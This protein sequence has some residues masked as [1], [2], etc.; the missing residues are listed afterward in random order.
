MAL[1]LGEVEVR[2][3]ALVEQA[4]AVVEEVEPEVE[5]AAGELVAVHEHVA[6]GQVPAARPD[7][8]D[9]RV[10]A[11]PVGLLAGIELDRAL[12]RVGQVGLAVEVVAPRRRVRV[13]EVGHEAAGAGVERVDDHLAV[14]RPGDLDAP[15]LQVGGHGRD[16]PVALAHLA[17]L[18][19]EVGQLAG[20]EAR[21]ALGARGEEL[22]ASR[23]EAA[24]EL[25]DERE[26]VRAQDLLVAPVQGRAKLQAGDLRAPRA[27]ASRGRGRGR[28]D[29]GRCTRPA[30]PSSG[31][32]SSLPCAERHEGRG[33]I[34]W[35]RS[36]QLPFPCQPS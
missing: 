26:R 13:L 8:E 12:D 14:D 6:L 24:V 3:A 28:R 9:G 34:Q 32:E 31:R 35:C 10:V 29:P 2:A 18:R 21:L 16:A 25:G 19:Q 23:V 11:E 1:E 7:E 30:R 36:R 20:V 22:A 15:V 33:Q 5:E 17:R 4:P 27:H